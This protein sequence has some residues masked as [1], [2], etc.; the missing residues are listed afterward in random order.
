MGYN[1]P[2]KIHITTA[3]VILILSAC[4]GRGENDL[5]TALKGI[6]SN[7]NGIRDDVDTRIA[8]MAI[9]EYKLY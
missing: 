8:A 2:M 5:P 7:V 6:D 9:T 1:F 3:A 4:S